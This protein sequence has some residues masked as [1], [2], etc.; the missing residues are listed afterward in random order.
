MSKE[1]LKADDVIELEIVV[2]KIEYEGKKFN[3]YK[4]FQNNG[5]KI[6]VKFTKDVKNQPDENCIILVE[7][8]KMNIDKNRRYP[9][10]WVREIK[11]IKPLSTLDNDP[12]K[13]EEITKMFGDNEDD[14]PF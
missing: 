14:L 4:T 7:A 3:A 13:L 10:V 5:K 11:E 12:K 9:C 6:D 1:L 2:T 8:G